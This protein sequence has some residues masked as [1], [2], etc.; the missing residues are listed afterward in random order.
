MSCVNST[1][2]EETL[3]SGTIITH[4]N[5]LGTVTLPNM[6]YFHIKNI[7]KH[8]RKFYEHFFV[9]LLQGEGTTIFSAIITF[10]T[11]KIFP[12]YCTKPRTVN[13]FMVRYSVRSQ[14]MTNLW[15]WDFRRVQNVVCIRA[16]GPTLS[17]ETSAF[18]LQTPGKFPEEYKLHSERGE[19]LKTTIRHLYREE[20]ARNIRLLETRPGRWDRHWVPKRRIL[21]FRR[22]GNSQKNT[23][24]NDELNAHLFILQYVYYNP[25]HVSSI[26]CSSSGGW[27]VLMQHLV[28][29]H[30]K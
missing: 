29:S 14:T 13:Q 16:M 22:R 15:F 7:R 19:S 6:C 9:T 5:K 17:P 28:S 24:Y 8:K 4:R 26:I 11:K 10:E 3:P 21:N 12:L 1:V 2:P 20:T 23:N 27:I 18:K 30:W 25:L